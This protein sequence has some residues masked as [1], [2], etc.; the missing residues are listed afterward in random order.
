MR[1]VSHIQKK[2]SFFVLFCF[3]CFFFFLDESPRSRGKSTFDGGGS[4]GGS[5]GRHGDYWFL[6]LAGLASR[7]IDRIDEGAGWARPLAIRQDEYILG[8]FLLLS[9]LPF[10]LLVANRGYGRRVR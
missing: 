8:L 1:F 2:I 5:S 9:P 10:R 7:R 4:R 3:F 6:G